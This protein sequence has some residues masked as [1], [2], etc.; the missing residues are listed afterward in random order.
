MSCFQTE[1]HVPPVVLTLGHQLSQC[2]DLACRVANE[3]L[4]LGSQLCEIRASI[5]DGS[6]TNP[7]S[8]ISSLLALDTCVISWGTVRSSRWNYTT[9]FV[10][11]QDPETVYDESY[12]VYKASWFAGAWNIQRATRIFLHEAILAQIDALTSS[13]SPSS[14]HPSDQDLDLLSQRFA[15]LSTISSLASDICASVPYL[16]GHDRPLA[17]QISD[18]VPAACGYFLV[19]PLYLAGSTVGVPRQLRTYVLGRLRYIGWRLGVRQALLLAGILKT[20]IIETVGG[21]DP[22]DERKRL[23][24]RRERCVGLYHEGEQELEDLLF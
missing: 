1:S 12:C 15:S 23:L 20:R 8:I 24:R 11:H 5:K 18:P 7:S 16:L 13:S 17:E 19:M 6:F 14:L 2:S 22:D 21:R 4:D 9:V 3:L 10:D